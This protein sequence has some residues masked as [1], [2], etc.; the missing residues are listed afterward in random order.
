[1][2]R[3]GEAGICGRIGMLGGSIDTVHVLTAIGKTNQE[4]MSAVR[5]TLSWRNSREN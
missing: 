4:A 1:M 2:I 5:F 3:L